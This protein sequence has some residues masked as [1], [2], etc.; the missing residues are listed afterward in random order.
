MLSEEDLGWT[1]RRRRSSLA[2][3]QP[4]AAVANAGRSL[5]HEEPH[6]RAKSVSSKPTR[7]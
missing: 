2:A 5:R 6:D 1:T 4:P 7:P 3:T